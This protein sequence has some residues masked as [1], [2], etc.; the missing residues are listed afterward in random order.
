ML[1]ETSSLLLKANRVLGTRLA[2]AGL[3]RSEHMDEANEVF[4]Q[5][6]RERDLKRASLLRILIFDNQTLREEDLLDHQL[7]EFPVG[8]VM[9]DNYNLDDVLLGQHPAE[10][11][12]ASWTVPIDFVNNRWFL[13]TAYYMSDIVRTFWEERLDG[14]VAWNISPLNQIEAVL[15][16][17]EA[18]EQASGE[19]N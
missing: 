8:A 17:I 19:E 12:R 7:A 13:A 10:F 15:E 14:R 18:A 16:R 11:L 6:A 4:I 1:R 3:A 2:E 5:R 9:L